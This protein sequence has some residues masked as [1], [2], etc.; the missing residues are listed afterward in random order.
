MHDLEPFYRWRNLYIASEDALSP[1]FGRKYSEF[2]FT[3]SIYNYCIHPQWDAFGSSTLYLKILYADYDAHF[4][5]L[6]LIGEWND[7]LHD[8]MMV[9]KRNVLETLMDQGIGQFI[10]IC[11]HLLTFHSGDTDYYAE[12]QEELEEL[13]P[14]GWVVLINTRQ[15]V[16]EE[17]DGARL[18]KYL[19]YG[20]QYNDLNWR[21]LKPNDLHELVS[22]S[23]RERAKWL[24]D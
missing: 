19:F 23:L 10:L 1:F 17:M 4:A 11:D 14:C 22:E 6:E 9:L 16:Q 2:H 3:H 20:S 7:T 18:D 21:I 5:V 13:R 12:L 15:H 24:N 8:D